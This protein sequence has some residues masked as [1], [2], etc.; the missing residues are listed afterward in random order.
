MISIEVSPKHFKNN[1]IKSL[2][3]GR[4]SLFHFTWKGKKRQFGIYLEDEDVPGP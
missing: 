4:I 3:D 2:G 1:T